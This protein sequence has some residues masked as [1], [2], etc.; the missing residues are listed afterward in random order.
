SK[1]LKISEY[2]A[3]GR[4]NRSTAPA[5]QREEKFSLLCEE[6]YADAVI[7]RSIARGMNALVVAL[8]TSNLFPI[9]HYAIKIAESVMA[10]YDSGQNVAVELLFDDADLLLHKEALFENA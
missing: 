8:R 2:A 4:K 5:V 7:L 3:I 9:E 6:T 10:F 1:R